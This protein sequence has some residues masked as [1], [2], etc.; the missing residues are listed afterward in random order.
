MCTYWHQ[1][2]N[3]TNVFLNLLGWRESSI[4]HHSKSNRLSGGSK[5]GDEVDVDALLEDALFNKVC[6][7]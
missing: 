2:T 3:L 6:N 7:T 5:M 1:N 4:V